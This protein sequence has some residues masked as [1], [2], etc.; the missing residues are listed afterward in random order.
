MST[1]HEG[2]RPPR[3]RAI[4]FM[5]MI[6]LYLTVVISRSD[7]TSKHDSL[8]FPHQSCNIQA[9]AGSRELSHL[10]D[11][12]LT[13]PKSPPPQSRI[14]VPI[15]RPNKYAQAL[16]STRPRTLK[17]PTP[18]ILLSCTTSPTHPSNLVRWGTAYCLVHLAIYPY[19]SASDRSMV[20]II[21]VT[22]RVEGIADL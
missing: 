12:A 9:P 13:L 8:H 11:A 20:S 4:E 16:Y 15:T 21:I 1:D 6:L 17:Q 22:M 5:F 14:V 2:T 10:L 3:E 7:H 18:P 19:V